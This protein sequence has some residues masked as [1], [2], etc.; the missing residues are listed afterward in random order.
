MSLADDNKLTL[1]DELK[2]YIESNSFDAEYGDR[3]IDVNII[4]SWI[5][6][7]KENLEHEE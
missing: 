6:V 4:Y 1:L 7:Q 3:Y 2:K 5:E